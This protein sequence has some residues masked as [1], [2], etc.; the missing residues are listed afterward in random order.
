MAMVFN[1]LKIGGDNYSNECYRYYP[2]LGHVVNTALTHEVWV[3][4]RD[5][6]GYVPR[7]VYSSAGL[8]DGS[9]H[10]V[11][12]SKTYTDHSLRLSPVAK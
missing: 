4:V 5:Q 9:E 1:S 11:G 3:L 6:V 12:Y 8:R 2:S 7:K 10:E